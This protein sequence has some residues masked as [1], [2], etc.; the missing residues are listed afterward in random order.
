M[1]EYD[2]VMDS[3]TSK[4]PFPG[5]ARYGVFSFA[6]GGIG[7]VGSG[8]TGSGNGP[9]V[10]DG[11]AYNP[12]TNSWAPMAAL[13]GQSR[14][15]TTSFTTGGKGY[16]HGGRL[17]SLAFSNDLFAYDPATNAWTPKPAMTGP[18]RSWAMSMPFAFDAVVACGKDESNV[19]LYD[20]YRYVPGLDLWQPIPDFPGN[21][22]WGGASFAFTNRVFGGLGR[23]ILEPNSGYFVDWW[24]L[25]K[26]DETSVGELTSSGVQVLPNPVG[27][28]STHLL[29][30]GFDSTPETNY[31]IV[32]VSGRVLRTGMVA[33][34]GMVSV[35]DVPAGQYQLV[36]SSQ[37][38]RASASFL[39]LR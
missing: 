9:Y 15:G 22:G 32:D 24:E 30:S 17:A 23:R 21:S 35:E 11:Y 34:G 12:S 13:P 27:P 1:F 7:Y 20:A 3:W 5:T 18:G 6:I 25:V 28:G 19:N 36:L 16:V 8:N 4:A 38:T 29:I 37:L 39:I 33:R 2:P 14:Y 31:S 10:S 26:V